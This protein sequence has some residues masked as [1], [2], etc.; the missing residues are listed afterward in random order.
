MHAANPSV[1]PL[2][3]QREKFHVDDDVSYFNTA[4]LSP[5]L[6]RVRLAGDEALARRSE[7]WRFTAPDW[8]TDSERLRAAFAGLIGSRPDDVALV[9]STSYGLAVAARNLKAGP[10]RRVL[11]IAEEFPSNYYTW[12]RF[13]AATGAELVAVERAPGEAWADAILRAVDER[14]AIASVPNVHWSDGAYVDLARVSAALH[15]VGSAFVIDASQSLGVMPLDLATLRPDA[16]VAV[17]YKWLLG[18][19]GLGYLYVDPRHHDGTPIEENWALRSGAD[20]FARLVGY[21]DE[22]MPGARRY[23]VGERSNFQLVPMSLA[24][25]E[26]V[27]AWGPA[28]I[29]ATL[30]ERTREIARA[31]AALGLAVPAEDARGPH[32]LGIEFP[33]ERIGRVMESL[34][35]ARVFASQRG[36][37]LRIAPH[38]HNN[39]RDVERLAAALAQGM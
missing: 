30:R 15:A 39:D 5:M 33:P 36:S 19:Y 4:N 27:A 7:P 18:P 22:Y 35:S 1:D 23:D 34:Q 13:A 26:Q 28:R 24:A 32:I 31:A 29:G 14:V 11:V 17:G 12:K 21:S 37:S 6:K 25:V 38:L 3:D 8:F 2:H 20:D 16:V 9:P 10:G